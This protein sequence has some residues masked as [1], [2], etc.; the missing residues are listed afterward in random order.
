MKKIKKTSLLILFLLAITFTLGSCSKEA[1]CD[2]ASLTFKN[3]LNKEISVFVLGI[4]HIDGQVYLSHG[5]SVTFDV[6][7]NQSYNYSI[8][9]DNG[10]IANNSVTVKNCVAKTIEVN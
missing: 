10:T 5:E 3:N 7:P 6:Y 1:Y 2:F 4:S 8:K 9:D